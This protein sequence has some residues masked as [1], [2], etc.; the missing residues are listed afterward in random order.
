MRLVPLKDIQTRVSFPAAIDAVREAFIAFSKGLIHQ[1]AP[2]QILF[3]DQ[4]GGFTGDC[5]VKAAQPYRSE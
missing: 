2:M 4:D 5:H 3:T 1:P